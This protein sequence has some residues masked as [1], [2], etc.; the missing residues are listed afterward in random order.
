MAGT[1]GEGGAQCGHS[2]RPPSRFAHWSVLSLNTDS[3]P[4]LNTHV[5]GDRLYRS[6]DSDR[7]YRLNKLD[8]N[9]CCCH[10]DFLIMYNK[11]YCLVAKA[12]I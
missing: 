12:V 6:W 8:Q 7:E 2:T 3:D 11:L 4:S 10:K 9:K 5:S 1:Y